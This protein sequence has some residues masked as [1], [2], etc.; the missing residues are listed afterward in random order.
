[1]AA[2]PADD[3]ATK[4]LVKAYVTHACICIITHIAAIP[5]LGTRGDKVRAELVAFRRDGQYDEN[6]EF[7]TCMKKLSVTASRERKISGA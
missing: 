7:P 4:L 2:H 1:M 3:E 5:D 6:V